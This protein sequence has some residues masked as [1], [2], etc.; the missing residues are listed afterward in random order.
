MRV[1]Y[2]DRDILCIERK[3][4]DELLC[5]V[6]NRGPDEYIYSSEFF[7]EEMISGEKGNKINMK[8]H[9]CA[10]IK[11]QDD[12]HEYGVYRAI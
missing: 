1:A 3:A 4:G 8:P 9:G 10:L 12:K 6:I 11:T 7:S 2:I 5:A